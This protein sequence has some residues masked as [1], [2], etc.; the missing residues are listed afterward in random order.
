MPKTKI[1]ADSASRERVISH[2]HEQ[3]PAHPPTP[4]QIKM[5]PSA[6]EVSMSAFLQH[7][8]FLLLLE[9]WRKMFPGSFKWH[10]ENRN[11]VLT[12]TPKDQLVDE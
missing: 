9:F 11:V 7:L 1:A 4:D 3:V 2:N 8:G 5:V 12:R 10:K 6:P